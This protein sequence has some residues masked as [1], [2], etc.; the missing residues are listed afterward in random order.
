[1]DVVGISGDGAASHQRFRSKYGLELALLSDP[2]HRVAEAYGA[3][4]EKMTY[5]K[6]SVGVI[7][8]TFLIDED[9]RIARAW[10]GVKADGHA[11]RVLEELSH[12]AL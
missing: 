11:S 3:Y 1:M 5:R 9:G 10:Y 6:P 4:G 7:R 8:S 12:P 2:D